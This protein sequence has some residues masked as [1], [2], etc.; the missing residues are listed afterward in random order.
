[1]S[2]KGTAM[3]YLFP[4]ITG[5]IIRRPLMALFFVTMLMLLAG[6]SLAQTATLTDD[7]YTSSQAQNTNNGTATS[8]TVAQLPGK[9]GAVTTQNSYLKFK[10]TSSLPLGTTAANVAKATLKVYVTSADIGSSLNVMRVNGSWDE[11]TITDTSGNLLMLLP[12]VSGVTVTKANSF[13]VVDL[14]QLVKDWLSGVQPN[15]GI[16]LTA[17]ANPSQITFDSKE[18]NQT[19]HEPRLEITLVN[20]GPQ[21]QQGT[22]G[23]KG[24]TGEAGAQGLQG[25]KGETGAIGPAGPQGAK[26]ETGTQ[27]PQGNAGPQGAPGVK[28]DTGALGPQ[29]ATGPQGPPG[30]SS[31]A[32]FAMLVAR[33]R[34]LESLVS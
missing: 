31:G 17:G 9:K 14:T 1:M 18:N 23:A 11:G 4:H 32:D 29:G 22:Q 15:N 27:G 28:G 10:L 13:V 8:L 30:S 19:S 33:I 7:A 24:D 25:A 12:E 6:T 3:T 16:A 21:G 34:E 20:Q 2:S 5:G 26:G